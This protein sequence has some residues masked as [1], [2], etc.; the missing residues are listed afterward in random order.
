MGRMN[1]PDPELLL[2]VALNGMTV[3]TIT[4]APGEERPPAAPLL[5]DQ[6]VLS[7][8][9]SAGRSYDHDLSTVFQEGLSWLHLAIRV[10]RGF[11]CQADCLIHT[12]YAVAEDAFSKGEVK[13]I[14]FQ[15]FH[16]PQ[17]QRNPKELVGQGLFIRGLHYP[18]TVTSGNV[19]L[20]CICDFC[21]NSFRLQS[22]HAGF[23]DSAYFYCSGGHIRSLSDMV[24][25]ELRCQ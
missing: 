13:D 17:C 15:P 24:S 11:E 1:R 23:G 3:C 12:S 10:G 22:F 20:S 16:L 14:R 4:Q 8:I 5:S 7:F 25:R 18:G 19:S 21:R 9:D 2:T 6:T